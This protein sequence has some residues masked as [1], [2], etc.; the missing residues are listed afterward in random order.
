MRAAVHAVADGPSWAR[1]RERP[2]IAWREPAR[3]PACV[4]EVGELIN[5][6]SRLIGYNTLQCVDCSNEFMR[7]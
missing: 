3:K 7:L 4:V 6:S 1:A 5:C 2:A